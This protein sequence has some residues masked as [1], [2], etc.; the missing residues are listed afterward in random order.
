[1]SNIKKPTHK[2]TIELQ[3]A[4]SAFIQGNYSR[5]LKLFSKAVKAQPYNV[6][7]LT[8]AARAHGQRFEIDYAEKCVERMIKLAKANHDN[9][10]I[11]FLAAQTLRMI[12]RS[13][14]AL[15]YFQKVVEAPEPP[16]DVFLELA[17]L[18]E[19][20]H[21][22]DPA[23]E[24][25][26]KYL[27]K[28]PQSAEAAMLK[29]RILRRKGQADSTQEIYDKMVHHRDCLP[30]TRA[31]ILNEWSHLLDSQK[32]FTS[33]YEKLIESKKILQ[34]HSETESAQQNSDNEQKWQIRLN[35]SVTSVDYEKWQNADTG[36]KQ[37]TVLL[38]GCPRSGTTLIEKII[39]AHP[40][41]ISADELG[42]FSSYILPSLV[43]GKRDNEGYFD[44][45]TLNELSVLK[46]EKEAKR[47]YK[48]LACA[49]N[50]SID[51][52]ILVDKN[53]STTGII[54]AYQRVSPQNKILYALRDPRDVALSCFFRWLPI[55]SVSVRY[56]TFE[57]TCRRTAEELEFWLD[58]RDK[59]P[60]GSWLETRY[61]DTVK[62]YTAES[63]RV[64]DWMGLEWDDSIEDYRNHLNQRGVNSP[65]YEAVNKP[66]YKGA[67][68]RWKNYLPF[69]EEHLP[70]LD[71]VRKRLGY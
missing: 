66:I 63:K 26:E 32:D 62:D 57:E 49:L 31:Q 3:N 53:P 2:D 48:Y 8:D 36:A 65:T 61:E 40:G 42:A 35:H 34:K 71:D 1:M 29:G 45:T 19:R 68:G 30:I 6:L 56:Q 23:L 33:A 14:E 59:L 24:Y 44:A 46:I 52:R 41:I 60:A 16:T 67:I 28:N 25:I 43:K 39:D 9:P 54:A 58:T 15:E 50:E 22:L 4:R 38:T 64:L 27:L 11:Y 47:Y 69:V 5:A 17:V 37:K 7:A 55:N 21:N 20:R 12:H 70:I 10:T 51:D 13:D 18:L